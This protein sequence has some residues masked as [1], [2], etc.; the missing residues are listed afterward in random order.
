MSTLFSR[1]I[2]DGK[3]QS[4]GGTRILIENYFECANLGA[5]A[6]YVGRGGMGIDGL[7]PI[8]TPGS[9]CDGRSGGSFS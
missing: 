7:K 9:S 6:L 3:S 8:V 5:L 1:N 2:S 4:Y